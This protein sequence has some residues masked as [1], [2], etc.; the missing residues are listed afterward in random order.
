MR[1]LPAVLMFPKWQHPVTPSFYEA[2]LSSQYTFSGDQQP[3][4]RL[5]RRAPASIQINC[6]TDWNVVSGSKEEV[7]KE[8]SPAVLVLKKWQ[9]PERK[10]PLYD[11]TSPRYE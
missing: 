11:S 5:Q 7:K 8:K 6:A 3:P 1:K 9:H 4:S 10:Q 2:T